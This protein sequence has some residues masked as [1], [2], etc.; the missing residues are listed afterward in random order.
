MH[1]AA[2]S[3]APTRLAARPS[4]EN[5][6]MLGQGGSAP[7]KTAVAAANLLANQSRHACFSRRGK[8]VLAHAARQEIEKGETKGIKNCPLQDG[9][10]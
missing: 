7:Q 6:P 3:D 5:A 2:P 8:P 4:G 1:T 9:N 10:T